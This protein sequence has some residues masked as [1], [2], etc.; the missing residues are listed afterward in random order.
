M[1]ANPT[2]ISQF[3]APTRTVSAGGVPAV[4]YALAPGATQ[5]FGA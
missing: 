4:A 1:F 5:W 2:R 3:R